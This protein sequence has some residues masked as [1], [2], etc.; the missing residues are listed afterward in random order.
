MQKKNIIENEETQRF[1]G[2]FLR[3]FTVLKVCFAFQI[4]RAT[5]EDDR[6]ESHRKQ[7]VH[8]NYRFSHFF[9]FTT[10]VRMM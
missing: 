4:D 6:A 8:L 3:N 2:Y 10:R 9:Y 7:A 1:N 5:E